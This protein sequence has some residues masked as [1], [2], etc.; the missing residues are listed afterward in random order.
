MLYMHQTQK[1][2][3]AA[4]Q[5]MYME[6]PRKRCIQPLLTAATLS[7]SPF[8][9]VKILVSEPRAR[10][11]APARSSTDLILQWY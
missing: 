4:A 11:S 3:H 7:F 2:Q 10:V 5:M 6:P 8:P 9:T 1:R